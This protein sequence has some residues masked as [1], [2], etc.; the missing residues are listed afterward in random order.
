MSGLER[1][2]KEEVKDSKKKR[3][4]LQI[5]VKVPEHY[6]NRE[7]EPRNDLL[8][9]NTAESQLFL[10]KQKIKE[11]GFKARNDF[12]ECLKFIKGLSANKTFEYALKERQ[13]GTAAANGP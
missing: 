6:L 8:N 12:M 10:H 2:A 4:Q 7:P 5:N 11:H 1:S 13:P 9:S 3:K